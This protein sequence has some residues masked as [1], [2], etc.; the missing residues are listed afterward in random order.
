[1]THDEAYA[2]LDAV[3]FDLLEARERDAVMAHV[4][5]C[6][7]CRAELDARQATVADLAFAAPLSTDTASGSRARIRDRLTARAKEE[8]NAQ[9]ASNAPQKN[10]RA[11][12][13]APTA[14]SRVGAASVTS[15]PTPSRSVVQPSPATPLLVPADSHATGRRSRFGPASWIAT[16]AGLMLLAAGAL[17]AVTLRELDETRVTLGNGTLNLDAAIRRADS[18]Q[19]V[20]AQRDSALAGITGRDVVAMTLTSSTAKEPYAR[21]YWDRAR[22]RWTMVAHD[23]PDLPQGRVYQLW[24]VTKGAKIS[25]GTFVPQRGVALVTAERALTEPPSAVAITDEPEGGVTEPTGPIII[26]AAAR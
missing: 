17:L 23:L 2:E 22:H 12:K 26:S 10:E 24:I 3:A 19:A 16:A 18:L 7:V 15:R 13:P 1:M 14:A 21:M 6:A 11:A 8:K 4:N 9:P 25:A 20:V 5:Q